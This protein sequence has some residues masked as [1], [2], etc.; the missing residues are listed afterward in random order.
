MLRIGLFLLT[1]LAVLALL[2]IIGRVFGIDAMLMRSGQ[3]P[4]ALLAFAGIFGFV[5]AFISLA[6]S[7]KLALMSTRAQIIESPR[8]EIEAWL[9]Q[10]VGA[11]A[12]AA[13]IGMPDVAIYDAPEV[14]AFATGMNRNDA[15]VAVS[16]GLLRGM[17]REEAEAVLAHE[18]SHVANGDMVTLAL[19]QGVMNTFVIFLSRV[20][21]SLID[22]A[23][24]GNREGG[25]P[26]VAYYVVSM[27]LEMVFGVLALIVVRWFSR[28]REFRADAG[29]ARLRGSAAMIAALERLAG[30]RGVSTLP[31][32]VQAF[33]ISGQLRAGMNRL[34]A[35]HPPLSERIAA[36]RA[37][38]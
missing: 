2:G 37:R 14:N 23:L 24:R 31:G 6:L 11:Q 36:L 27:V 4:W 15:L 20:V 26:G 30:N 22:S 33:G 5:G 35:T 7:K 38:A 17:T 9:M 8:N 19:V 32:E 28:W 18:V 29:A 34:F 1:N 21:G 25:G 16:T 3:N 10:T 13:G 12:R